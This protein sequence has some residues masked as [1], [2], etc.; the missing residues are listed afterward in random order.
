M[1]LKYQFVNKKFE[2]RSVIGEFKKW[3]G[4]T[5]S[6]VMTQQLPEL[7][8]GIDVVSTTTDWSLKWSRQVAY[9]RM[10]RLPTTTNLYFRRSTFC[11]MGALDIVSTR[12]MPSLPV[13]GS[14]GAHT[15]VHSDHNACEQV[16]ASP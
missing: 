1:G 2:L 9:S 12:C 10:A 6:H 5:K 14:R 7:W 13:S 3:Q 8:A 11:G 4:T 15:Q 16:F